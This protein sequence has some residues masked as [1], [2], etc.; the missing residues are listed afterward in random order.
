MNTLLE[1]YLWLG[2]IFFTLFYI[3]GAW[4]RGQDVE[5][6]AVFAMLVVACIP[7]LN[8]IVFLIILLDAIPQID[9]SKVLLKG[10]KL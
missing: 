2:P 5:L 1:A 3:W 9:L 6:G 4:Y 8:V 10:R 7:V